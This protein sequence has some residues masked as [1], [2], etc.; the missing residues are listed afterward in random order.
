MIQEI[1]TSLMLTLAYLV[2]CFLLFFIGKV[3]YQLFHRNI[4]VN[5]ELVIKDNLAFA[6]SNTGYYIGLLFAIA[7][8]MSGQSDGLVADLI[9]IMTYGLVGIILL[10]LSTIIS[11]K[12]LLAKFKVTE[13]ITG[14]QN[15]GVGLVEGAVAAGSGMIIFAALYTEGFGLGTA[16]GFWVVGQILFVL[17]GMV[18]NAIVPYDTHEHLSKLN[19]AVGIGKAGALIGLANIMRAAIMHPFEDWTSTIVIISYELVLGLIFLPICRLVTDKILLPGQN[20]TDEIV[21]QEHP[22]IGAAI[23]EAFAYIGGS[24]LIT[25]AI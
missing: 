21:N 15:A 17:T 1:G 4:K 8:A 3:A 23:I 10:N 12:F 6:L 7:G 25:L 16:I 13:E 20:L 9:A 14:R 11:D 18:Y 5:E 22:N 19:V 2:S 24:V